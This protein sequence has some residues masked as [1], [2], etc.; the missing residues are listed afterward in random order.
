MFIL[1]VQNLKFRVSR[2][3]ALKSFVELHHGEARVES[4]PGKGSDFCFEISLPYPDEEECEEYT[5]HKKEETT[6]IS[7]LKGVHITMKWRKI[8]VDSR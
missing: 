5:A 4:E 2:E 8:Y 1:W 7:K 3:R 6:E